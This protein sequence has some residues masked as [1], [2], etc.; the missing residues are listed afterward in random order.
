M[1]I[2]ISKLS[3]KI[4]T[5]IMMI[6]I[7]VIP[8]PP[9]RQVEAQGLPVMD[10]IQQAAT[11]GEFI[12]EFALD[13][14]VYAAQR[15][16]AGQIISRITNYINQGFEAGNKFFVENEAR[17]MDSVQN[18]PLV[19]IEGDI[20]KM[21]DDSDMLSQFSPG[22][23]DKFISSAQEAAV[24][25]AAK[26]SNQDLS[27][28]LE[29]TYN[30]EEFEKDITQG[31]WDAWTEYIDD[32]NNPLG[33][34]K[35]I[36]ENYATRARGE[37]GKVEKQLANSGGYLSDAACEGAK[38][39]TTATDASL[40]DKWGSGIDDDL[41]DYRK[42]LADDAGELSASIG[43]SLFGFNADCPG[44]ENVRTPGDIIGAQ[45][46]QAVNSNLRQNENATE[47][48]QIVGGAIGSYANN[49]INKGLS[50][51]RSDGSSSGPSIA[52]LP[53]QPNT[54]NNDTV[55][56][57]SVPYISVDIENELPQALADTGE[58]VA[59][60]EKTIELY[61]PYP[62]AFYHLDQCIP[63]PE[64]N[65]ENRM[66]VLFNYAVE[67]EEDGI[68]SKDSDDR[69]DDEKNIFRSIS[70]Q[71][72]GMLEQSIQATKQLR[73]DPDALVLG[74]TLSQ[75]MRTK[76]NSIMTYGRRSSEK[77]EEL[78][79][80]QDLYSRIRNIADTFA[81]KNY[82]GNW[83]WIDGEHE[84]TGRWDDPSGWWPTTEEWDEIF[85][86]GI[87]PNTGLLIHT[88]HFPNQTNHPNEGEWV[89]PRNVPSVDNCCGANS[90]PNQ[91]L[92]DNPDYYLEETD[93][94][95]W[96]PI[97][98]GTEISPGVIHD[99]YITHGGFETDAADPDGIR[100]NNP[101]D[102]A[103]TVSKR[104]RLVEQFA[105][106]AQDI[107]VENVIA[108]TRTE[109][110]DAKNN[111]E[112]I[113]YL[114]AECSEV[115]TL[116]G[117]T[118]SRPDDFKFPVTNPIVQ[119]GTAE[120]I[121]LNSEIY[122]DT[123]VDFITPGYILFAYADSGIG[124]E[125]R[126]RYNDRR[127]DPYF[128][129]PLTFR[130]QRQPRA[131]SSNTI[132]AKLALRLADSSA[133]VKEIKIS[134]EPVGHT[135][136]ASD[137]FSKVGVAQR[138]MLVGQQLTGW[139]LGDTDSN[140]SNDYTI[141][142]T[143]GGGEEMW[144]IFGGASSGGASSRGT[145][146]L[147][148]TTT[149]TDKLYYGPMPSNITLRRDESVSNPE[150]LHNLIL[151]G[152][153]TSEIEIGVTPNDHIPGLTGSTKHTWR[154]WVSSI[155]LENS[156]GSTVI[157]DEDIDGLLQFNIG[158]QD[159]SNQSV[160]STT[161]WK[162]NNTTKSM[163]ISKVLG[164]RDL[165]TLDK[166][167][168][169]RGLSSATDLR[170]G[171]LLDQF[172]IKLVPARRRDKMDKKQKENV[173]D[174]IPHVVRTAIT[175]GPHVGDNTTDVILYRDQM[176]LLHCGYASYSYRKLSYS[177]LSAEDITYKFEGLPPCN[178]PG[179]S[180]ADGS[181]H[182]VDI[183]VFAPIVLRTIT[184]TDGYDQWYNAPL[185]DYIRAFNHADPAQRINADF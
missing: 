123:T 79:E 103:E 17:F 93:D 19:Q 39:I 104:Q 115:R 75:D 180:W 183:D 88:K 138:R 175:Y 18:I 157:T 160:E 108:R 92:P 174:A 151:P 97:A 61:E 182:F 105:S 146:S 111:Y 25:I 43:E 124:M 165:E 47:L 8:I 109:A 55:D 27:K 62:E 145:K 73:T 116:A 38:A 130:L 4:F 52:P 99:I 149:R 7:T 26:K 20:N 3:T 121:P 82:T 102:V 31:G 153:A 118:D 94:D 114:L 185:S 57:L 66:R 113:L 35:I 28:Q 70:D 150:F 154:M 161:T 152:K 169:K 59:F 63:G 127:N 122:E 83:E 45:L 77:K 72:Q 33:R 140:N 96:E 69:E 112:E 158:N 22:Y 78:I 156:E 29:P 128:I 89:D 171:D 126:G 48:S 135:T 71:L 86:E 53:T 64:F 1:S 51:L 42:G 32:S 24:T 44:M 9:T 36:A 147:L 177:R 162:G 68:D 139:Q 49:L 90:N 98:L 50:K 166:M 179:V 74:R 125:R 5:V 21:I 85:S 100:I 184:T 136:S 143:D 148:K 155:T 60:L 56:W 129:P 2:R 168:R 6:L 46:E 30:I 40:V 163:R 172:G 67:S 110:R 41:D 159:V 81:E 133:K 178:P 141:T 58:M 12:K 120:I 54:D 131:Y 10:A 173:R 119:E 144:R 107:P 65:W 76:V 91:T 106:Y 117:W 95:Y 84:M 142:L 167:I 14:A 13:T 15:I 137:S 16:I 37:V 34:K 87:D 176:N 80:Q 101:I 164:H 134:F 11:T 170:F 181:E 132:I 23:R